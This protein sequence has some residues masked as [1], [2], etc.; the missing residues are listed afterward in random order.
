MSTPLAQ[1]L[2]EPLR[3]GRSILWNGKAKE[4]AEV[5]LQFMPDP[6]SCV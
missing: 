5:G 6:V 3:C 1:A 4:M 2:I